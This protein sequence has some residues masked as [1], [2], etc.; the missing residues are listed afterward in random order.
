[1][2]GS[3]TGPPHF[4]NPAFHQRKFLNNFPKFVNDKG[5]NIGELRF[6][7]SLEITSNGPFLPE[8]ATSNLK[9]RPNS[10]VGDVAFQSSQPVKRHGGQ[11]A[12][13]TLNDPLMK[14]QTTNATDDQSGVVPNGHQKKRRKQT[15]LSNNGPMSREGTLSKLAQ[16]QMVSFFDESAVFLKTTMS[17]LVPQV[18]QLQF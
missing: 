10:L 13:C 8:R 9:D 14:P 4:A 2:R 18:V 7:E 12:E 17:K 1:M 5:V 6:S 11:M 16:Q 3:I 15:G